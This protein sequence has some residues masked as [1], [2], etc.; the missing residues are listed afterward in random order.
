MTKFKN[1]LL[2]SGLIGIMITLSGCVSVDKNGNPDKDG[3][4]YRILVEPLGGFLQYLAKDFNW[5]YGLAIIMVTIIV[6]IILLPLG[7]HQSKQTMVQSEKMQFL[8][9][10]I[11]QAQAKLKAATSPEEQMQAQKEMQAV[12][13]ENNVSMFGGMG[14]LPLLIQMPIFSALYYTARF[15]PGIKS[16]T[17]MG[18]NLGDPS[19]VLVVI[20]GLFYLIQGFIS[21]IGVPEEQ[22]K[23]M[24]SMLIV[25]PLMIVFMSMSAPAG[26]TLYWVVGGLISCLQTFITNVIMKPRIKAQVQAEMKKNPPKTVVTPPRKDVTP[27]EPKTNVETY[28]K[29]NKNRNAGK[30]GRNV[31]KQK[32]K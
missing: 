26:V 20:A 8:K 16:A 5:G 13:K 11:D 7:I 10:Q 12:Y 14:C 29:K 28:T 6:R 25:S 3:M 18:I 27:T 19:I 32:R 24:R 4:I 17:F 1:W 9:P 23:T 15:T 2:A 31:G 22:K 21:Q 30:Q